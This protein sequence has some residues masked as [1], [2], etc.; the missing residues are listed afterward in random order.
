MTALAVDNG[1]G[2][3]KAG[4][5]GDHAP[6]AVFPPTGG[7]PKMPGIMVGMD[8]TCGYVG[9]E[10]QSKSGILTTKY[11]IEHVDSSS[12]MCN[13]GFAHDVPRALPPPTVG[14]RKMPGSAAGMNHKGSDVETIR[15]PAEHVDN[16]SGMCNTGFAEYALRVLLP[17][18]VDMPKKPS[19]TVDINRKVGY[20]GDETQSNALKYSGRR[21][22]MAPTGS[23]EPCR[24]AD[25]C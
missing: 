13:A 11:P 24:F 3:W 25:N 5:S 16:E 14:R 19:S 18:T 6:H 4:H 7:R 23:C 8:Q 15:H 20:V 2:M 21:D 12:G 10:A 1:S 22:V 17:S 9:D